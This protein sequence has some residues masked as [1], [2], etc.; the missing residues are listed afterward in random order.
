MFLGE[1]HNGKVP[2]S[3]HKGDVMRT[4]YTYHAH[5]KGMYYQYDFS[6]MMLTLITWIELCSP[7][8]RAEY[9]HKYLKLSY[10]GD[11]HLFIY[12]IIYSYQYGLMNIYEYLFFT[13]DNNKILTHLY[14]CSNCSSFRHFELFQ[15]AL[16]PLTYPI[17]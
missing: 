13:L 8:L 5:I 15:L 3:S 1:T 9:L 12:E 10:T 6:L 7:F 16:Y 11:S 4:Y 2:L 14:C 17:L